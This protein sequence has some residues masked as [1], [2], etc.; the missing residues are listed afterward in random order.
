MYSR[1]Y[2]TSGRWTGDVAMLSLHIGLC[3]QCVS[4]RLIHPGRSNTHAVASATKRQM[5]Q[6]DEHSAQNPISAA[7]WKRECLE[8]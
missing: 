8:I 6:I 2:R 3:A 7:T 4:Q 5:M 1:V